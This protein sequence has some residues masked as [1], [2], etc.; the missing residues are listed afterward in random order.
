MV[1]VRGQIINKTGKHGPY[2]VHVEGCGGLA[3][4]NYEPKAHNFKT[5]LFINR[6]DHNFKAALFINRVYQTVDRVQ[7]SAARV[8]RRSTSAVLF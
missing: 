8:R 6:V 1:H 2:M 4:S 5:A 7:K 3:L